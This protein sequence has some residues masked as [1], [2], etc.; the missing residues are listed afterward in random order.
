MD[1]GILPLEG[2]GQSYPTSVDY[3]PFQSEDNNRNAYQGDQERPGPLQARRRRV[4]DEACEA[5]QE[6]PC[7]PEQSGGQDHDVPDLVAHGRAP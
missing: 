4:K 1:T 5:Q 3:E 6:S 2:L 7:R